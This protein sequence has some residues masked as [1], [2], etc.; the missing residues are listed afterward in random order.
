MKFRSIFICILL[1]TV[2]HPAGASRY[3]AYFLDHMV[4]SN[5]EAILMCDLALKR[6]SE[7]AV[8]RIARKIARESKRENKHMK[9]WRSS[10]YGTIPDYWI[11]P[12]KE[13]SKLE[14][15]NMAEFDEAFLKV[16]EAH[17]NQ[18]KKRLIDAAKKGEKGFIT[19]FAERAIKHYGKYLEE[20]KKANE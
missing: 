17:L 19:T 6:T 14:N 16:I 13:V 3:D 20:I 11:L 2:F 5:K 1:L 7:V 10:Y 9:E 8:K 18:D 15:V 12:S 4:A